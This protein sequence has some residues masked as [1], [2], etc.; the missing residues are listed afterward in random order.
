MYAEMGLEAIGNSR[1]LVSKQFD[2]L[3]LLSNALQSRRTSQFI[4]RFGYNSPINL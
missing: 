3:E 4:G 2:L 1:D